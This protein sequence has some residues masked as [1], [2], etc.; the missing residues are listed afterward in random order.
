MV[1]DW[2]T[3]HHATLFVELKIKGAINSI[4]VT[5]S[6]FDT[7]LNY[8]MV[9]G[10]WQTNPS[11]AWQTIKRMVG[12]CIGDPHGQGKPCKCPGGPHSSAWHTFWGP[13]NSNKGW[14]NVNGLGEGRFVIAVYAR[15]SGVI[16]LKVEGTGPDGKYHD[17][18][19]LVHSGQHP[20]A[21]D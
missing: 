4:K 20:H 11:G 17:T 3:Y 14:F 2:V 18:V 8:P 19:K 5:A 13:Y 1:A 10:I 15:N 6:P 16:T 21:G 12:G 9:T 7:W